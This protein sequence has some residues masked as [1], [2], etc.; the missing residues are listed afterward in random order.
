MFFRYLILLAGDL[1]A[2]PLAK[3]VLFPDE[4]YD[5]FSVAPRLCFL[6][7]LDER[8]HFLFRVLLFDNIHAIAA[9]LLWVL[10]FYIKYGIMR[11]QIVQLLLAVPEQRSRVEAAARPQGLEEP[12]CYAAE[13]RIGKI[14]GI[15]LAPQ[16]LRELLR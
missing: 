2:R 10:V 15:D 8:L 9:M 14:L 5:R 3:F 13:Q 7:R 16:A 4:P 11:D 12:L 6:D 1:S